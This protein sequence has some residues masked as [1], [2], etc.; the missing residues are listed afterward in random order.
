MAFAE[1]RIRG[2]TIAAEEHQ[3]EPRAL[4]LR[5]GD[6]NPTN[7]GAALLLA[8]LHPVGLLR[9]LFLDC[10]RAG[11]VKAKT[12]SDVFNFRTSSFRCF[13]TSKSEIDPYWIPVQTLKSERNPE[14][15]D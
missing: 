13:Q 14:F 9:S 12:C 2:E 7:C 6:H 8:L 11:T 4:S 15:D 10:R 3:L 1:S 5:M